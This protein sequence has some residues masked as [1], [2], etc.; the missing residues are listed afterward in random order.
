MTISPPRLANR[1]PIS[2]L[3]FLFFFSLYAFFQS[4]A[5]QYGDE[6]EK[7]RVAQSL[8]ERGDFSFRPTAER[9]ATGVG[10][11]TYSIYEL[12]QTVL[13]V[14]FYAL[15]RL[16]NN[17]LGRS[18]PNQIGQLFVGLLN[19]LVTAL[20]VVLLF[21]TCVELGFTV[22]MSL[23]AGLLFGLATIAFPYAKGFTREPL[24]TF[25]LLLSFYTLYRFRQTLRTQRPQ[26]NW[27]LIAAG[28]AAGYL[29]FTKFIHG[30]AL[31]FLI[32]YLLLS[33]LTGWS[34]IYES[35]RPHAG[36]RSA[37]RPMLQAVFL[38]LLPAIVFMLIQSLYAWVRFGTFT[39]GG[40][41]GTRADPIAWI[42]MLIGESHP[43]QAFFG[44]VFS[45]Q[46]SFLLYSPPLL[47]SAVG[48]WRWVRMQTNE[49]LLFLALCVVEFASVLARPDWHGGTWWGPR[50]LVQ[51]TPLLVIPL[52][53]LGTSPRFRQLWLPLLF[54]L[55][56]LGTIVQVMGALASSRDY[57]DVTGSGITLGGQLDFLRHG[58]FDLW[59]LNVPASGSGVVVNPFGLVLLA[60]A[61]ISVWFVV[62]AFRAQVQAA[63]SR[64]ASVGFLVSFL[65]VEF[66]ALVGWVA[67]PYSA[68]LAARGDTRLAAGN[69]FLVDGRAREARGMYLLAL[70]MGTNDAW[71][72]A[73]RLEALAPRPR[74]IAISAQDLLAEPETMDPASLAL[75]NRVTLFGESLRLYVPVGRDGTAR[76]TTQSIAVS[77]NIPYEISGWLRADSIYGSGNG[78]ITLY[79]DD[80]AWKHSKQV[81]VVTVDETSG[82]RPFRK[83][84][85]TLPTTRRV[86]IAASLWNTYGTLWVDGLELAEL[87]H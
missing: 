62:A 56:M 24:L 40:I 43:D 49:A 42:V 30:I 17:A 23:G 32:A 19:P 45:P 86:I 29:V 41:A 1:I 77:G 85:Q 9:N 27:W 72:A 51:I 61:F 5:I 18:D 15:A 12:G 54:G 55:G 84:I 57:L 83:T 59:Y 31:P 8:V 80:G 25:L 52:C 76:T 68:V 11:R 34:P 82:W 67:L 73:A 70:E 53:A 21:Q 14:P 50:Y 26:R 47:L 6:V 44:L 13:E 64:R 78:V 87:A 28:L 37:M 2:L 66:A 36:W 35:R 4:G 46:K 74:G 60:A 7:Y 79:E 16:L 71:Q 33:V 58:A 38:F 75:D 10:G 3:L 69:H 48:W 22:R 20:T 81:D 39:S 65:L 63:L